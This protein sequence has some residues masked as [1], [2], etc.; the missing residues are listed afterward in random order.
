MT[1]GPSHLLAT[2]VKIEERSIQSAVKSVPVE[3][4]HAS[5]KWSKSSWPSGFPTVQSHC[6][7]QTHLRY[8]SPRINRSSSITRGHD[9]W[10]LLWSI[11]L[12]CCASAVFRYACR[13]PTFLVVAHLFNYK[14]MQITVSCVVSEGSSVASNWP[15]APR[16]ASSLT[17]SGIEIVVKTSIHLD[18]SIWMKILMIGLCLK[19]SR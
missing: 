6:H 14:S 19:K 4:L 5:M 18:T 10:V 12:R 17:S 8:N 7:L 15:C 11:K 13:I 2:N 3:S 9:A 16:I 1:W